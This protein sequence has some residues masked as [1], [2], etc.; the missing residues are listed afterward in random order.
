MLALDGCRIFHQ[1][2]V[3]LTAPPHFLQLGGFIPVSDAAASI[4]GN[5]I[6]SLFDATWRNEFLTADFLEPVSPCWGRF[7]RLPIYPS[8]ETMPAV[9]HFTQA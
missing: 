1:V 3:F 5:K 6:L 9:V 2:D 4:L 8:D 7:G